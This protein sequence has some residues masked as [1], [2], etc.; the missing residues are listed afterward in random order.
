MAITAP[1]ARLSARE[2]RE[3]I[4][5]AAKPVFG[6]AGYHAATTREIAAAAGVSEALLYQH[7]PGKRE[8]FVA[9]IE[10]AAADLERRLCF[11]A[12]VADPISAGIAAYFDFVEQ[13]AALYRVFFH[14]ALQADPAFA[15]LYGE[16]SRR[17]LE[18]AEESIS[19]IP[20]ALPGVRLDV[21]AQALA[22]MVSQLA[23]WWLDDRRLEK[24]DLVQRAVRMARAIYLTEASNGDQGN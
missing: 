18:L 4:L 22:G 14:Q 23:L 6:S 9:V 13:E 8:L 11:E 19:E 7:F 16:L 24:D 12:G 3:A 1:R 20:D 2:R 5:D 21:I 17:F 10:R 15:A